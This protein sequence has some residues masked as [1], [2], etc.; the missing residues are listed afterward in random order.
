[1]IGCPSNA[2]RY[3][4]R[5]ASDGHSSCDSRLEMLPTKPRRASGCRLAASMRSR[6]PRNKERPNRRRR[7]PEFHVTLSFHN[8]AKG[9]RGHALDGP[10][11]AVEG[12]D[13]AEGRA[14]GDLLGG[15]RGGP[16][17]ADGEGDL[18]P[19]HVIQHRHAENLRGDAAEVRH[20]PP[21]EGGA[22]GDASRGDAL[23]AVAK[24]VLDGALE[25]LA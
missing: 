24:V 10:E 12:R 13:A 8:L 20:R 2:P 6:L 18:A 3:R 17:K 25:P 16:K 15:E 9:S 19:A 23:V 7:R 21:D 4:R 1:M 22:F 14:E 5:G 11:P